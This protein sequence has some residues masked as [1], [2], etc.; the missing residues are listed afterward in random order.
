MAT[1]LISIQPFKIGN[2]FRSQGIEVDIPDK[3]KEI[4]IF[5]ANNGFIAVLKDM[6]CPVMTLVKRNGVA[7]QKTAHEI[8]EFDCVRAEE[9]MKVVGDKRPG[10]TIGSRVHQKGRKAF[11][12][13]SAISVVPENIPPFNSPDNHMLQEVLACR[14]VLDE[15]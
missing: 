7:G 10:E 6:S 3:L 11:T 9:E 2:D 8:L 1:P 5:F 4:W 13:I 14:V 15:A 12:K